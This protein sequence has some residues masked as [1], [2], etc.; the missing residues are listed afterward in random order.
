LCAL[1]KKRLIFFYGF[2][3]ILGDFFS[4]SSG[5]PGEGK[6]RSNPLVRSKAISESLRKSSLSLPYRR[7]TVTTRVARFFL[8]QTYQMGKKY[9]K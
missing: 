7:K 1:E 2:G 8:A 6:Q 9:T 3:Y 5:H 4:N